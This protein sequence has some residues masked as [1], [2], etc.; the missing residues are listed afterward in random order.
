[1]IPLMIVTL[2]AALQQLPVVA[3]LY[4]GFPAGLGASALVAL[5]WMRTTPGKV[6]IQGERVRVLTV[7]E[8]YGKTMPPWAYVIDIDETD[9][10]RLKVTVGLDSVTLVG[11]KWPD[12]V[13]LTKDLKVARQGWAGQVD[14]KS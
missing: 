9:H 11:D 14:D 4:K 10:H 7:W 1:M 2:F 3:Y 5:F 13:K 8:C 6:E 12:Y